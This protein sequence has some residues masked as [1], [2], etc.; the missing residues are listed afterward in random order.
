MHYIVKYI[1]A[2]YIFNKFKQFIC[3]LFV[4]YYILYKCIISDI[5]ISTREQTTKKRRS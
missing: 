5:I 2:L 3:A 4:Q 1:C